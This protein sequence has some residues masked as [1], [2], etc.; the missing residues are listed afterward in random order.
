MRLICARLLLDVGLQGPLPVFVA[1][2]LVCLLTLTL[3]AHRVMRASRRLAAPAGQLVRQASRIAQGDFGARVDDVDK[4]LGIREVNDLIDAFN[5][6]AT[7]LAGMDYLRRDFTSSVSHEFKTP[8][9]AIARPSRPACRARP[10]GAS[11]SANLTLARLHGAA[12]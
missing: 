1:A 6:M 2:C 3:S 4:A 10:P 11:G 7:A 5:R 12:R 9:A 8:V